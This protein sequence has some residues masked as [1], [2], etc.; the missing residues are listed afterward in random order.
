MRLAKI[1]EGAAPGLALVHGNGLYRAESIERVLGSP[2]PDGTPPAFDKRVFS[3]AMVGLD[4]LHAELT[5]GT[6]LED[7]RVGPGASLLP[8]VARG[9]AVLE[10]SSSRT[11]AAHLRPMRVSGR[12]LHGHRG[13][14]PLVA[15]P[16]DRADGA[17]VGAGV[18]FVLGEDLRRATP[19]EAWD[20]VVGA[21]LALTLAL[22]PGSSDDGLPSLVSLAG[23]PGPPG[24]NAPARLA[25]QR[26]LGTV[27][28]PWLVTRDEWPRESEG[29][30]QLERFERPR[31]TV[32]FQEDELFEG[33]SDERPLAP[34]FDA[35]QI[36][37]AL[38]W[39]SRFGE[40]RAG[41]VLLVADEPRWVPAS[42][43]VTVRAP[44]LGRLSA[45]LDG[46]LD[47]PTDGFARIDR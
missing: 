32:S 36:G 3:L 16:G 11:H 5:A 45:L 21:C 44:S 2:L 20:A 9:A 31:K 47:I 4:T 7:T 38:S 27:L 41:D 22:V 37:G 8:P 25:V 42:T 29:A 40:L 28:G 1:F 17:A 19:R 13:S 6:H 43:E 35:T 46:P 26:E 24:S 15:S 18:A 30:P 34:L 14:I 10:L 12:A 23:A 33:P 39:I